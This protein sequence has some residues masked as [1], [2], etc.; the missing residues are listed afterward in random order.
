[1]PWPVSPKVCL[2]Q[3]LTTARFGQNSEGLKVR[4]QPH[5]PT[6]PPL[7]WSSG[8]LQ[9]SLVPTLPRVQHAAR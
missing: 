7:L 8:L 2:P 6:S 4:H 1:M 3:G 9:K 5:P